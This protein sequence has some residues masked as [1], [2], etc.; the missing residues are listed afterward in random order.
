[1]DNSISILIIYTG[2]T[3]GMIEDP[4]TKT[5]HP[6]DFD[7]ILKQLPELNQLGHKIDA[8]TFDPPIDSANME[9]DTWVKL[10]QLLYQ[11]YDEYDGFVILHGSDTMS[12]TASALS[13]LLENLSKPVILTGSQ[14]PI[15][16]LRTDG[17]D[18][19]I[20]S[21]E[22]AAMRKNDQPLIAEVCVYFENVLYRGNRS[23]KH[24]AEN[25]NAFQSPNYPHL[26]E[27]GVH[28]R[29]NEAAVHKPNR[30]GLFRV[31]A[32]MDTNVVVL[33]IF[34][35]ISPEVVDAVLQIKNLKAIVVETYGAGN[36]PTFPWFVEAIESACARGLIV[37]NV[38]QC[39][40][41]SV[42]MS[43][44]ETGVYLLKAGVVSGRD[45]TTEA[46]VTKLMFLLGQDL[47]AAQV[48][49][50]LNISIAGEVT[51]D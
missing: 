41:G 6:F 44:Y 36:A 26:A 28:I 42:E 34:P 3:I 27:A 8:V 50:Y 20:T 43:I 33:K 7:R 12:F 11:R 39:V 5:L 4:K 19:I 1:M 21:V 13:F 17:K 32:K 23:T 29:Y 15:G 38:T 22:I 47:S 51:E 46:A 25:F 14:L 45:M 40:G 37:L 48:R 10:A 49:Q 18:N 24:N 16:K 35:G 30:K 31:H 9:P 2:G